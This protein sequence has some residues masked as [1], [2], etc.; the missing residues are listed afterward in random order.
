M[1]YDLL[2]STEWLCTANN[3]SFS[4]LAYN[5]KDSGHLRGKA[6]LFA[7]LLRSYREWIKGILLQCD[8][9]YAQAFEAEAYALNLS[10]YY[11][12][13]DRLAQISDNQNGG[14]QSTVVENYTGCIPTRESNVIQKETELRA[15]EVL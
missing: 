5:N 7:K 2:E 1:F 13:F 14:Y 4:I 3:C 9:M 11:P 15:W 10:V 6:A 8:P 12:V